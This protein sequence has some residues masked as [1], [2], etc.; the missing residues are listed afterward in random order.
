MRTYINEVE[1]EYIPN[2]EAID[3]RS[4][5]IHRKLD[6]AIKSSHAVVYQPMGSKWGAYALLSDYLKEIDKPSVV[7]PYI[8]IDGFWPS[9]K[10]GNRIVGIPDALVQ[11]QRRSLGSDVPSLDACCRTI[12]ELE[13]SALNTDIY[14]LNARLYFAIKTLERIEK[15]KKTL[16]VSR[17]IAM[18]L[19]DFRLMLTQNHPTAQLTLYC[20]YKIFKMLYDASMLDYC[21]LKYAKNLYLNFDN[22]DPENFIGGPYPMT[23]HVSR[24][25]GVSYRIPDH[26]TKASQELT[27]Q[28]LYSRIL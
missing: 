21:I 24:I 26:E 11:F 4:R 13:A 23:S 6:N 10:S 25:L 19:R 28:M 3:I 5:E 16:P 18:H 17:Y 9:F 8:H 1:V 7:V 14:G 15:Q 22:I 2:Y 27:A 20:L 12:R